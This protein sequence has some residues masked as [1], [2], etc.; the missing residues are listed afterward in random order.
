MSGFIKF[1]PQDP[2]QKFDSN[3]QEFIWISDKIKISNPYYNPKGCERFYG[4]IHELNKSNFGHRL[5]ELN[6]VKRRLDKFGITLDKIHACAYYY[7]GGE[8]QMSFLITTSNPLIFWYK[9]EAFG[10]AGSNYL[11]FNGKRVKVSKFLSGDM[12]LPLD[13]CIPPL[14]TR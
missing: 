14:T 6:A 13:T 8:K 10:N 9:Y 4:S 3:V 5:H 1:D 2:M 12:Q 11:T 7:Y